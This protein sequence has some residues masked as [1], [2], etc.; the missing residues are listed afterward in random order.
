[1]ASLLQAL[2]QQHA[3]P[4]TKQKYVPITSHGTNRILAPLKKISIKEGSAH[5]QGHRMQPLSIFYPLPCKTTTVSFPELV[6]E[7]V[8]F[9]EIA[10]DLL[11]ASPLEIMDKALSMF[12]Q[13]AARIIV[14]DGLHAFHVRWI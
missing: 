3:A 7:N 6:E 5:A 10:M 12:A 4:F 8:D 11:E 2:A 14:W 9:N 1:M 13:I